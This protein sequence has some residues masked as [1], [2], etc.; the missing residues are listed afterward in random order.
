MCGAVR[1]QWRPL[2]RV[3]FVHVVFNA[4]LMFILGKLML[5]CNCFSFVVFPRI[6]LCFGTIWIF[7][8]YQITLISLCLPFYQ[9]KML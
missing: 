6:P 7:N 5:F 1:L 9:M 4:I 8:V 2:D 3:L